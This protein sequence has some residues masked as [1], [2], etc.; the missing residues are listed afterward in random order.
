M[1][2]DKY[3]EKWREAPRGSDT[4]GRVFSTDLLALGD[5]ALLSAWQQM[6]ARRYEGELG[7]LGPLYA[8]TFRECEVLDLGCGLGFDGM[9]FLEG[10]ARWTFADIVPDN[11]TVVRRIAALK[12]LDSRA[13]FHMIEDTFSFDGL[14]P[15]YDAIW[16]LGSLHHVP[17]DMAR[18]EA[19]SVLAHLKPRGRWL[20]LVYPRERWMREGEMP[21]D[22]WGTLTDGART[23][24]TEWYDI[25]KVRKRLWPA[26][27]RTVLDFAFCSN[28]YRWIDLQLAG[29]ERF[30]AGRAAVAPQPRTIDLLAEGTLSV[31]GARRPIFA[32]GGWALVCPPGL[33]SAAGRVDLGKAVAALGPA[34]G[35]A[36]DLEVRVSA[37]AVS[38]G[39]VD[40]RGGYLA[41]A[42]SVVEQ[43][44]DWRAITLR[45][46]G[47]ER[48][49]GL[50]V[51][52]LHASRR[53]AFAVRTAILREAC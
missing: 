33:F 42:E 15:D 29:V 4:D 9:R 25:E 20:E 21:F 38:I 49:A 48:P 28:N 52:G 44:A 19:L 35:V 7:W 43:G 8:D 6:A 51:R 39:L 47:A 41:G 2:L 50:V 22:R 10:G 37:G 31:E 23:P 30:D 34:P 13:H 53:S 27:M 36:V 12:G 18:R 11:L 46:V 24:W 26:P 45:A 32:A 16:A 5:E 40:E 17:F 3:R 1:R 14:A